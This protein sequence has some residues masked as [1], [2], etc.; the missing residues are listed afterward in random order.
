MDDDRWWLMEYLDPA[1]DSLTNIR[2]W[3]DP[4][5]GPNQ[6]R[7]SDV[8]TT[9]L[10]LGTYPESRAEMYQRWGRPVEEF[11]TDTVADRKARELSRQ[12]GEAESRMRAIRANQQRVSAMPDTA[13]AA[14]EAQAA[15]DPFDQ[16]LNQLL[17][18]SLM[19]KPKKEFGTTGSL[20]YGVGSRSPF[21]DPWN[22][23]RGW[24]QSYRRV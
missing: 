3:Y 16:Y 10:G 7:L 14:P 13:L 9:L 15:S 11:F 20:G 8:P 1:L 22:M 19:K 2:N 21:G 5:V 4:V 24:E 23:V 6:F 12:G 18:S 17:M